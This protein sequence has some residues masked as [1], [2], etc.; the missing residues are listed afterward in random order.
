MPETNAQRLRR[1][2]AD[3]VEQGRCSVCRLRTPKLGNKVCDFCVGQSADRAQVYRAQGLCGCG[4][5]R[6]GKLKTCTT[7]TTTKRKAGRKAVAKA[8]AHG[9]C[10]ACRL[11]KPKRGCVTC[12]SCIKRIN[13]LGAKRRRKAMRA[14]LCFCGNPRRPDHKMCWR[15][16]LYFQLYSARRRSEE[17]QRG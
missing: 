16:V 5:K 6:A 9:K 12:A 15:H 14:E 2:R 10:P 1:L 3:A 11:R 8:I 17:R 7:C 4:N 13:K